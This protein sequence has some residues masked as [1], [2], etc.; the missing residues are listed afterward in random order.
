MHALCN[1]S[2]IERS[3]SEVKKIPFG[4]GDETVENVSHEDE[5]V[6]GFLPS[7]SMAV[8]DAIAG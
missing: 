6:L 2:V 4:V 1:D 3:K 7:F 5:V 8:A